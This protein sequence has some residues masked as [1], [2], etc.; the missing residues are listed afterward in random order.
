[1]EHPAEFSLANM[2]VLIVE[3]DAD[4]AR[5]LRHYAEHEDCRVQLASD[6]DRA[7]MQYRANRPDIVLLDINLPKKDGFD[8]LRSIRNAD[9][10]PI[11]VIS[12]RTDD[13]NKL[14]GLGLGADDYVV[15]PFNPREVIARMKAVLNRT[16]NRERPVLLR[17]SGVTLDMSAAIAH[18]ETTD[19][20][21]ELTLTPG[22]YKVLE[23]LMRTPNKAFSREEILALCFPDSDALLRTIDS[24][25][26][27]LRKKLRHAG[28]PE[29][30]S[31]RRGLGYKFD[32]Q[33]AS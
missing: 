33:N 24:H 15:K 12:A 32:N 6:G 14:R 20:V 23:L 13:E 18:F 19:G 29:L 25:I 4:I 8:V 30:I 11:I 28:A 5:I 7:L 31:V 26:S 22:E 10:T 16:Y 3:D 9:D 2:T 27:H 21:T 1:M 17:Q